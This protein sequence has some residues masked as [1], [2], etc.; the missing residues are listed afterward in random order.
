[1][2]RLTWCFWIFT[3]NLFQL[4]FCL[5]FSHVGITWLQTA[6]RH[7]PLGAPIIHLTSPSIFSSY[8]YLYH[9]NA[10]INA[11]AR[12][13]FP[14][15]LQSPNTAHKDLKCK[16]AVLHM[17]TSEGNPG[18]VDISSLT[19]GCFFH[20]KNWYTNS[21]C[22]SIII[23]NMD[24]LLVLILTFSVYV[25]SIACLSVLGRGVPHLWLFFRF[26][27]FP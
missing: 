12:L 3:F 20:R 21:F 26:L 11:G 1:M 5:H 6:Y 8:T 7:K 16:W 17:R 27:I 19:T 4:L 25:A 18:P 15:I 2:C 9:I 24:I 22:I 23:T 10:H 13:V 14:P